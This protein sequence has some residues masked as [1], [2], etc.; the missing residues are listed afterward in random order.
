MQ[1]QLVNLQAQLGKTIVFIT[2]DLNEAMRLGD[3]IAVMRAGR[4]VQIGTSEQI[5]NEP[6]DD[7]VSQFVQDV[8]R[9]RVLTAA[10]VAQEQGPL[11]D[12]HASPDDALALMRERQ[13]DQ[14]FVSDGQH[15]LVGVLSASAVE[16]ARRDGR[17]EVRSAATTTS[18]P[19]PASMPLADLFARMA[20]DSHALPVVDGDEHLLG[21]VTADAVFQALR[22]DGPHTGDATRDDDAALIKE[23]SSSDA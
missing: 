14:L 21:V 5:L 13:T 22:K 23:G 7:Y 17:S 18:D 6:A 1:D 3:R 11:V 2:H 15:K 9:S 20:G 10:S 12:G 8:D 19:V 4:I 16:Q